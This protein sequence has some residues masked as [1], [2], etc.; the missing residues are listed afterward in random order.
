MTSDAAGRGAADAVDHGD[1]AAEFRLLL[2]IAE[3]AGVSPEDEI[4]T[5]RGVRG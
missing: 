4:T 1:A 5:L 2:M 3:G